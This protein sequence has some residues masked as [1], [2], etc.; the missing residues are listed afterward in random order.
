[1]TY[2][3][4][5]N[6][7]F[8]DP[9]LYGG[10]GSNLIKMI[11]LGIRVPPGFIVNTNAF[12]KFIKDSPL[13]EEIYN[14]LGSNYKPKEVITLSSKI[15]S[16]FQTSKIPVEIIQDIKKEFNNISKDLGEKASF[17]V[18][19]S[20]NVEDTSNF[21]F[22]GQVESYLNKIT[23]E[24]I[25]KDIKNCWISLFSPNALLYLIQIRKNNIQISLNELQMAVIIQKMIKPQISGVLFTANVIN[26]E[27]DEMLINSTWGLGETIT[28]NLIIPDLIIL[29]KN[30]FAIIKKIIGEKEKLAIPNPEGSSTILI[31]TELKLKNQC[32]LNESQLH[33]LHILGLKLE[34]SF[35]CPQDIEW[36]IEDNK[37]YTLQSRPI[38]TLRK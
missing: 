27:M 19:S 31:P 21:S 20:A 34:K 28:S 16:L 14:T 3:E 29:N 25:L 7:A 35:N 2:V 10:K 9:N 8:P 12:T 37:L 33:E 18:R 30:K 36:A 1:M 23:L 4:T 13:K 11:K 32:S 24:E 6:R 5:I 38:T 22:A 17:S 26:N 15:K